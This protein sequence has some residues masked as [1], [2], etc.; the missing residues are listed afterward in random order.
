MVKKKSNWTRAK[1]D[2]LG[3]M[4]TVETLHLCQFHDNFH[5][6]KMV[7]IEIQRVNIIIDGKKMFLTFKC[8]EKQLM[9]SLNLINSGWFLS[10]QFPVPLL[11][12]HF[13]FFTCF[14]YHK[15]KKLLV[16]QNSIVQI[17]H[18]IFPLI[19]LNN[20]RLFNINF[21]KLD[22]VKYNNNI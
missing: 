7:N 13:F 10:L 1:L 12:R 17:T 4:L 9:I 14:L 5:E 20:H 8:L 15:N 11:G 16:K 22:D 6:K 21:I 3:V 19:R 18:T 2:I